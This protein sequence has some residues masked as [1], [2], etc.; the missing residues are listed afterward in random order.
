M[1]KLVI[2]IWSNKKINFLNTENVK[3]YKTMTEWLNT[4][5]QIHIRHSHFA[6]VISIYY[7]HNNELGNYE[8]KQ[9]SNKQLCSENIGLQPWD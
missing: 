3:Q 6:R 5:M 1:R 8:N 4:K 7:I 2:F 9:V